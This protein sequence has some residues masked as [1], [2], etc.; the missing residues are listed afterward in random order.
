M[1]TREERMCI[2]LK[3]FRGILAVLGIS[4]T[5]VA[6]VLGVTR[7]TV[8]NWLSG[9]TKPTYCQFCALMEWLDYTLQLDSLSAAQLAYVDLAL[10]HRKEWM[11]TLYV[12][13]HE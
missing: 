6:D 11:E 7:F 13:P 3:G 10:P 9:R 1:E 5:Y 4:Q 8:Y 2:F 12:W